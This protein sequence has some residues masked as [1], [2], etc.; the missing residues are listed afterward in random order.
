M[1]DK[2]WWLLAVFF[3]V[4]VCTMFANW[5]LEP[6]T[7]IS[8]ATT[9]IS[10]E[11]NNK[12]KFTETAISEPIFIPASTST[13]QGELSQNVSSTWKYPELK[14]ICACESTGDPNKEP[15]HFTDEGEVIRGW[16]SINGN[17]DWGMCQISD[18]YWLKKSIELGY[19]IFT[20]EGNLKMAEWLYENGGIWHWRW[21]KKCWSLDLVGS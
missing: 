10:N 8:Q 1:G 4:G 5:Y 12:S 11:A 16:Y 19:D 17:L 3:A 14:K 6:N 20:Q 7:E 15:R 2:I 9:N 18:K 21:S 13:N